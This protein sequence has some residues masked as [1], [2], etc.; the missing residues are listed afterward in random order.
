M[1]HQKKIKADDGGRKRRSQ[2]Q[3]SDHSERLKPHKWQRESESEKDNKSGEI[4]LLLYSTRV[5]V[6]SHLVF[7]VMQKI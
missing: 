1:P 5:A 6:I 4:Q 2:M 3:K 7:K